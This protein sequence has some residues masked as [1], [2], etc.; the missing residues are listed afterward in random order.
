MLHF[1]FCLKD[2]SRTLKSRGEICSQWNP[3]LSLP[4]ATTESS[5]QESQYTYLVF[6][7]YYFFIYVFI[8]FEFPLM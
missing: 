2:D 8:I 5:K 4:S 6:S 3:S 7:D 1:W